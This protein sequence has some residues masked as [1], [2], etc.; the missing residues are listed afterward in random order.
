[1]SW[2]PT[3]H[4]LVLNAR[5][6][7][8]TRI[9][10]AEI[11]TLAALA[12]P[13]EAQKILTLT[14]ADLEC[15]DARLRSRLDSLELEHLNHWLDTVESQLRVVRAATI[16]RPAPPR[17]PRAQTRGRRTS[18]DT[19]VHASQTPPATAPRNSSIARPG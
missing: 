6:R 11:R 7:A 16:E 12:L 9:A 13:P 2:H 14:K 4:D 19:M 15:A 18:L 3:A 10:A 17:R 8:R 1:M 5:L